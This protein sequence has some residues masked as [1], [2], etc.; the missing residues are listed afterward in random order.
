MESLII[1]IKKQTTKSQDF[2]VE[3]KD[4]SESEWNSYKNKILS[5][6]KDL[7]S[8]RFKQGQVLTDKKYQNKLFVKGIFVCDLPDDYNWGYDLQVSI[9]R[10]R[11]VSDPWDLRTQIK[12]IIRE[13]VISKRFS[14]DDIW[15]FL[16]NDSCGEAQC[17]KHIEYDHG[18]GCTQFNKAFVDKFYEMN[19]DDAI[20]VNSIGDSQRVEHFGKK[21]A[22]VSNTIKKIVEQSVGDLESRIS[23]VNLKSL[24]SYSYSDL[25]E[26]EKDN[27]FRIVRLIEGVEHWFSD[28]NVEIVDFHG[29]DVKGSYCSVSEK[30]KI[31][32]SILLD[33]EN[34]ITTLVH[35]VA[36]K[37]GG[38][39]EL[40]HEKAKERICSEIIT[41]LIDQ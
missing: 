39:A 17:F 6:D 27:F 41:N 40:G 14:L 2:I 15:E 4:V 12:N 1:D 13:G 22:V 16:S 28:R 30:V 18:V 3:I 34:L 24:K 8:I 38:D 9:N 19:G 36:H 32:K 20:P 31:S 23:E 11:E 5:F 35:E 37:Y 7:K 29:K 10:D 21:G 25:D 33:R 26:C